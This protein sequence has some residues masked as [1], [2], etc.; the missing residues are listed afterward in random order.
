VELEA[1]S[2]A[3][4]QALFT[5]YQQFLNSLQFDIVLK[6]RLEPYDAEHYLSAYRKRFAALTENPDTAPQNLRLRSL[7]KDHMSFYEKLCTENAILVP[8]AYL[9]VT[10]SHAELAELDSRVAQLKE[11]L[12]QCGIAARSLKHAELKALLYKYTHG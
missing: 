11:A 7:L 5:A 6:T 8:C 12:A 9:I 3:E 10:V 1:M 2:D 4:R